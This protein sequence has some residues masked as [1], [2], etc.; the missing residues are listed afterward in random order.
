MAVTITK[1]RG[2]PHTPSEPL[3][4]CSIKLPSTALHLLQVLSQEASDSLG[5]PISSSTLVRVLLEY[6]S[7]QPPSWVRKELHPLIEEEIAQGR[8]WGSTGKPALRGEIEAKNAPTPS[9][10]GKGKRLGREK[11]S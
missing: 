2:I 5:R 7:R 10:R 3:K 4:V 6:L 11:K 8:L 9:Q 1:K